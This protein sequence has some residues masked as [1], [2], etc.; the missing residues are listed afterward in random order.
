MP[1]ALHLLRNRKWCCVNHASVC[2]LEAEA[3]ARQEGLFLTQLCSFVVLY[4][5]HF[6]TLRLTVQRD[7]KSL[8]TMGLYIHPTLSKLARG[9]GISHLC[10]CHFKGTYGKKTAR[11]EQF[12]PFV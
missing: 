6:V 11:S 12:P 9:A 5:L 8:G 4:V 1:Y 7:E 3:G 10:A 2:E